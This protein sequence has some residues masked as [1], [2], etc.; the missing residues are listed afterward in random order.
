MV[1]LPRLAAALDATQRTNR[2]EGACP[3]IFVAYTAAF[4]D[5]RTLM[6]LF[7]SMIAVA[8]GLS[9]AGCSLDASS[10]DEE[11]VG[12]ESLPI[13]NG[14]PDTTHQAVVAIF[15]QNSECTGTMFLVNGSTGYALTAAHCC[16]P[17]EAPQQVIQGDD[18]N[19]QQVT[20]YNVTA[21]KADPSYDQ[22]THDFCVVQFAGASPNTPTIPL[23]TKALDS[24]H[25]GSVVE[26]VGYGVTNGSDPN[27]M[28][29]LRR[30]VTGPL[31]MLTSLTIEYSQANAGPC[32]GDSGG[33]SLSVVNGQEYVSGV[34]SYGDQTCTQFGVS[35]R[36]SG[37]LD[38]FIMAW[39]NGQPI[40]QDC[41][42]CASAATTGQG[43]CIAQ[44][45]AC[46]NNADCSALAQ[47]FNAC[48]DNACYQ[49][50][51]N[52]HPSGAQI[53]QKINDCICS[54]A[55]VSECSAEC[56]GSSSS[57]A[58]STSAA[59]TSAA[60]TSAASTSAAS[61]GATSG[62]QGG[63]GGAG[64]GSDAAASGA[65]GQSNG[66]GGTVTQVSAC[67]VEPG[68]ASSPTGAL[69]LCGVAVG[70]AVSRHRRA[71]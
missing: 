11:R 37:V 18:Y 9:A 40:A 58:S 59:A 41:N 29:S 25:Q 56:G 71:K 32:M 50:C 16:T 2:A 62:G 38:S 14:T 45:N 21:Y 12:H 7:R 67:S 36:V 17:Q 69:A 20:V 5:T 35:G 48:N 55:C 27:N 46:L 8:L 39:V 47:C 70:L 60:S 64:G 68:R 65:G 22:N 26:F 63:G 61:G 31:D 51:I 1:E 3:D 43:A 66:K 6:Q 54:Q 42:G 52:Q 13:I 10:P 53:Y 30:H 28:N 44:A 19:S 15:S 57:S 4:F 23:M 24:L 33:P 49:T 34:T